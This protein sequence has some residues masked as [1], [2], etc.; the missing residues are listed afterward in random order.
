MKMK[1]LI[2][3]SKTGGHLFPGL[4]IAKELKKRRPD[5]E[6]V[7][8]GEVSPFLSPFI[9]KEKIP[10]KKLRTAFFS[11]GKSLRAL[12]KLIFDL[13][14]ALF[15]S[16]SL[17][18]R[19]RPRVVVGMGSY[20]SGPLLFVASLL[21]IPTLIQE[22]NILPGRTTRILAPLVDEVNLGFEETKK[23]LTGKNLVVTGNPI[24]R[25]ILKKDYYLKQY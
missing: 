2:A 12:I 25:Q 19:L 8:V 7:L 22:Q 14:L 10:F 16:T 23:Y 18:L 4:A 21:G 15:A 3:V 20:A 24:R 1:I 5:L 11:Q 17:L 13:L 6:I 9:K